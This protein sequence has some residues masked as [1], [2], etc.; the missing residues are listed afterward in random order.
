MNI[1]LLIII[2][3]FQSWIS[4]A[5]FL[6]LGDIFKGYTPMHYDMTLYINLEI[7]SMLVINTF[8]IVTSYF[9]LKQWIPIKLK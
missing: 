9:W 1:F 5:I 3:F 6:L 7:F 2:I 4:Q 8:Y